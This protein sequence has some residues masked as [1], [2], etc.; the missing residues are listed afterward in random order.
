M[1]IYIDK[2][3]FILIGIIFI[4]FIFIKLLFNYLIRKLDK[5]KQIIELKNKN[6]DKEF[7]NLK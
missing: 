2:T 3:I 6:I 5:Q 1:N 4:L 7:W